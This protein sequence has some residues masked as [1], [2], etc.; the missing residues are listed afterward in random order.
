MNSQFVH[1]NPCIKATK[2]VLFMFKAGNGLPNYMSILDEEATN[3]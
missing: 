2:E 1:I 3:L